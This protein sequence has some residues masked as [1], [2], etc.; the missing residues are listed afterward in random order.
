MAKFVISKF[1][2]IVIFLVLMIFFFFWITNQVSDLGLF[3][4]FRT[5][6][7]VA[8]DI[9]GVI[10]SV[11]GVPGTTSAIYPISPGDGGGQVF[12]Y[13]ILIADK[14][15]CAT[16]FLEDKAK[17]TTDCATHPFPLE[18]SYSCKTSDGKLDI[19]IEK[20]IDEET[21]EPSLNIGGC[22]KIA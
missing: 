10:T 14:I 22:E 2:A 8:N 1:F 21:R 13:E 4:G 11:G 5:S 20:R 6:H 15:V 17:S 16:S 3:F 9:A 7:T 12:N 19:T 18:N